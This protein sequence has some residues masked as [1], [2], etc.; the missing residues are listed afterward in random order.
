MPGKVRHHF[1]FRDRHGLFLIR[2]NRAIEYRPD[3]DRVRIP[4]AQYRAN[5][6]PDSPEQCAL[7]GQQHAHT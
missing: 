1:C 6:R 3:T 2:P 7:Q 5:L 4:T